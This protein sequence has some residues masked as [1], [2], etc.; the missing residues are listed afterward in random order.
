MVVDR[1]I[2]RIGWWLGVA[3]TLSLALLGVAYALLLDDVN[4][5]ELDTGDSNYGS[6]SWSVLP[7]G[8]TCTYTE[9]ANGVAR[10]DGPGPAMT[11]W[12]LL[13]LIASVT[14]VL[15]RDHRRRAS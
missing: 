7:P 4:A 14:L 12:L 2:W 13:L 1:S 15:T 3:A 6:L 10:S 9:A 5:C 11:I 8:P